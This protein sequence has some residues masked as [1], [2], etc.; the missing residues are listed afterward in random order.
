MAGNSAFLLNGD[1]YLG[2]LLGFYKGCHVPF[3]V[4]RGNVGFLGK[5]CRVKRPHLT[6]RGEFHGSYGVVARS[7]EFLSSCVGGLGGPAHVSSGK[8]DLL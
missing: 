4:P 7:L 8:S 2:K 1:G 6:W 3:C 5:R